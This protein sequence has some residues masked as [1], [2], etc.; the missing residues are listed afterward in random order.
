MKWSLLRWNLYSSKLFKIKLTR[1]VACPILQTFP[2]RCKW[3]YFHA[4]PWR[5]KCVYIKFVIQTYSKRFL[6]HSFTHLQALH[7]RQSAFSLNRERNVIEL[8]PVKMPANDKRC[9]VR[10]FQHEHQ[11]CSS[12]L[13]RHIKRDWSCRLSARRSRAKIPIVRQKGHDL[14]PKRTKKVRWG[15]YR[16]QVS[17]SEHEIE[18]ISVQ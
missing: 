14:R 1:N 6:K 13:R 7:W 16:I 12:A 2:S 5:N 11:Y 9:D 18:A 17:P 3:S 15:I 8:I 10:Y 4:R